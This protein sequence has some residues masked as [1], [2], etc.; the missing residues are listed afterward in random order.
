M[1][2]WIV[3]SSLLILLVAALRKLPIAP[4]Q[5][6]A[7]WLVV[8]VRLLVPVQ[9]LTIPA[10]AP[11]LPDVGDAL[12]EVDLYAVPTGR[13]EGTSQGDIDAML[14]TFQPGEVFT[15]SYS[16]KTLPGLFSFSYNTGC[17]VI[18]EDGIYT[19][20]LYVNLRQALVWIYGAGVLA[21]LV[22]LWCANHRFARR[23]R[24][25]RLPLEGT[26]SRLPVYVAEGMPSPC[27]FGLFHPAIY[28]TPEAAEDQA[29]LCHI[30]AH[31]KTHY[32]HGDHVW[33][34][35][36][37]LAL[38]LH[39][40]NPLVWLAVVLSRRDGELCCDAATL[41]RLGDGERRAYGET[42]LKLISAEPGPRDLL[43]CSTAMTGG[44][45]SL[46]ERFR[47]IARR[48]RVL[49]IASIF[50]VLAALTAAGIAFGLQ[51]ADESW[52]TAQIMVDDSGVPYR[53]NEGETEWAPLGEPIPRPVEWAEQT[54]GGRNEATALEWVSNGKLHAQYVSAAEAWLV[55]TYGQGV[56]LADTYVY[57]SEDGGETW[58]EVT[59][60][61]TTWHLS[62]VGFINADCLV[63]ASGVFNGAPVFLTRDGGETWEE[64][65]LPEGAYQAEE[66]TYDGETITITVSTVSDLAGLEEG[67][68][69]RSSDL[70]ASWITERVDDPLDVS[71]EIYSGK[72]ILS[73]HPDLNRD[74]EPEDLVLMATEDDLSYCLWVTQ[75]AELLWRSSEVG[76]AHA[77]W[78]AYFL[79]TLDGEDFILEYAPGMWQG[80]C[81]YS[82]R[83]FSLDEDSQ[84]VILAENAVSFDINPP[85]DPAQGMDLDP[86][87]VAAFLDEVNGYLSQSKP[88]LVTDE[89]LLST[90]DRL[91]RLEDDL[92]WLVNWE[93]YDPTESIEENL[94]RYVLQPQ[95][96]SQLPEQVSEAYAQL[97]ALPF[98]AAVTAEDG[99][100]WS[101]PIYQGNAY[102]VEFVGGYLPVSFTWSQG[103]ETGWESQQGYLLTLS[104]PQR[105]MSLSARS[106][107]NVVR[108]ETGGTLQ[109]LRADS[110][111]G[112]ALSKGQRS[113]I[114]QHL[115]I[116]VED[117]AGQS[118]WDNAVVDGSVA[119]LEAVA[120]E[121]TE[122]IARSYRELPDFLVWKPNDVQVQENSQRVFDAWYGENPN[123]CFYMGIYVG[124][125]DPMSEQAF[126]WQV[127]SGLSEVPDFGDYYSWGREVYVAL[128]QEADLWRVRDAGTGGYS[129]VLPFDMAAAPVSEL[130]DAWFLSSGF[131]HDYRLFYYLC[132]RPLS[133]LT[134]LNSALDRRRGDEA[135]AFLRGLR[136]H[137]ETY[138]DYHTL[139]L[140]DI[141][142]VLDDPYATL[143]S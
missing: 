23:L 1:L 13:L 45:R 89:N 59:K 49:V 27:L 22:V 65:P 7:L 64:V 108:L 88:L 41:K 136:S 63:V 50:V 31:E 5:R 4:W 18:E 32:R 123:F 71:G 139:T 85:Q 37:C 118:V 75:G 81:D 54:V 74:G 106:G 95:A 121:M 29:A 52:R 72:E 92:W 21:A 83:V 15:Y 135:D 98:T 46:R 133:D 130:V 30:L 19:Y 24:A 80:V 131:T 16:E 126:H 38:T 101:Y 9:L 102:N 94:S 132:D 35:L 100:Q 20:A 58:R 109:Y 84:P 76:A 70:G 122:Q 86:A 56:A 78:G 2:E 17:G 124:I 99:Q 53:R 42:L 127:G 87:A 69:L 138:P 60:P 107:G 55:V 96:S 34:L 47:W 91:G 11:V 3:T 93:N 26:G 68:L 128:D 40:W 141:A 43:S 25:V 28:L 62:T 90:F 73:D 77:A 82:Y 111:D 119:D 142:S 39:W 103:D 57:R 120:A 110:V 44:G 36:R 14:E 143:F 104:N 116:I 137:M 115:L 105:G 48:P 12:E 33:S 140:S 125:T 114:F 61:P 66:I 97:S 113:A 79:C 134:N 6:Y 117:A 8:L 67:W 51:S 112:G 10:A 129:A